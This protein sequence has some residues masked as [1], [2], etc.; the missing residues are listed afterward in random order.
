MNYLEQCVADLKAANASKR[1]DSLRE[2]TGPSRHE[3]SP[4]TSA[5]SPETS[6]AISPLNSQPQTQLNAF[7]LHFTPP[8]TSTNIN[9][10]RRNTAFDMLPNPMV[11]PSPSLSAQHEPQF[12]RRATADYTYAPTNALPPLSLNTTSPHIRPLNQPPSTRLDHEA[13]AALLMLNSHDRREETQTHQGRSER[14]SGISVHDL[15]SH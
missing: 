4:T 1:N 13:S 12:S 15:L 7:P 9:I 8:E 14:K 5:S 3:Q 2:W 11:L 10:S 6:P